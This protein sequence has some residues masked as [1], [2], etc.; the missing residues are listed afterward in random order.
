MPDPI[1]WSHAWPY[2][3]AA[4]AGGYL[5]GS[6]PFGL[7][8]SR[9]AGLGDIRKIGSGNIGATNVLR[10]GR[11]DIALAT[12]ILDGGK[13]ALAAWIASLWG[14]DAS[15]V[16]AFGAVLGHCFPVWLGF[17]GGKAIATAFGV[18]LV[19]AWPVAA[20]AGATWL[21]VAVLSRYSS[22]SAL[23][24]TALAPLY[25][26]LLLGDLQL[27]EFCGLLAVLLWVRH[28]RNIRN[29]LTGKESKIGDSKKA[30]Q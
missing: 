4:F 24:A 20:A 14:P 29:L 16:A 28:H 11:K 1:S 23:I 25:A 9:A 17:R 5:L 12:V 7:L 3:L 27:V 15:L 30:A 6:V 13:G 26:W 22:L 10:T 18:M 21:A 8:L 2:L 19:I